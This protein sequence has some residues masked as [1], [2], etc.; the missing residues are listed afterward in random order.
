MAKNASKTRQR[1]E[2]GRQE[3]GNKRVGTNIRTKT[4]EKSKTEILKMIASALESGQKDLGNQEGQRRVAKLLEEIR[5]KA[6]GLTRNKSREEGSRKDGEKEE[7]GIF[8]AQLDERLDRLEKNGVEGGISYALKVKGRK[9][10]QSEVA[11][12]GGKATIQ[13]Y[14]TEIEGAEGELNYLRLEKIWEA[15]P[16]VK[17]LILH[18]RALDKV[19]VVVTS[20]IKDSL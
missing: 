20:A 1:G 13:I 4:L 2:H 6:S 9:P 14:I 11:A 18:P 15:I 12:L 7:L 5:A 19:M 8:L 3:K 10:L 17:A 16:R